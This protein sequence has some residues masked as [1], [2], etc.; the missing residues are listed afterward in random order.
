ML[1]RGNVWPRR[2][3]PETYS[4]NMTCKR[5][6]GRVGYKGQTYVVVATSTETK[7]EQQIG[8]QNEPTGG[9]TE[10]VDKWPAYVNPRV[11]LACQSCGH[12]KHEGD[13]Q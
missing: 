2:F 1:L 9:L 6:E 11:L 12:P 8:W 3:K 10:M 7:E 4:P 13:C 5:F